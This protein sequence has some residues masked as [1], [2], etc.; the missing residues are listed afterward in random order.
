[1]R[2]QDY[3]CSGLELYIT[4]RHLTDSVMELTVT[5]SVMELT[6]TDSVMELT[7]TDSVMA[8][9]TN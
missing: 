8:D 3:Y 6:V 2:N 5:D 7:V 9:T 1:M 4:Y